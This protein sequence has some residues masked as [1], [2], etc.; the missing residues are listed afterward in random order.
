MY[1]EDKSLTVVVED[2]RPCI[3]VKMVWDGLVDE[4]MWEGQEVDG[5]MEVVNTGLVGV[6]ELSLAMNE[7]GMIRLK[8]G[9]LLAVTSTIYGN[10]R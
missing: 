5:V 3:G 6:G 4:E 2:S 10:T 8:G 7:Y 1:G 9:F